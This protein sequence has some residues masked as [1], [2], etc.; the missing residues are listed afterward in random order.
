MVFWFGS[1]EQE[2]QEQKDSEG[3]IYR[4]KPFVSPVCY[5]TILIIYYG[6]FMLLK[7]DRWWRVESAKILDVGPHKMPRNATAHASSFSRRHLYKVV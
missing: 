7:L 1:S 5:F 2:Q 4:D 6:L 3:V